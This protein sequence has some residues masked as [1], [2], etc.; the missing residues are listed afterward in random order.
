LQLEVSEAWGAHQNNYRETLAKKCSELSAESYFL[1]KSH[2]NGVG[3]YVAIDRETALG[4]G[5]DIEVTDRA[6][7]EVVGRIST[8]EE[9][10]RCQRMSF[11][12]SAKEAA[13]KAFRNG[14]QPKT[15]SQIEIH[16]WKQ[17]NSQ[18]DTFAVR[19]FSQFAERGTGRG[20][21]FERDAHTYSIF[22]ILV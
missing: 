21:C 1:S 20:C 9:L 2:T 4:I 10:T 14:K 5:F 22:V 3:G 16:D 18:I 12:W 19:N 6:T 13:F 8:K 15:L 17:T 7:K 11:L